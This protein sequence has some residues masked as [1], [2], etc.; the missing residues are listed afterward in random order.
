MIDFLV[1]AFWVGLVVIAVTLTLTVL[2]KNSRSQDDQN[3]EWH[4]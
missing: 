4:P 2:D 1:G 3:K